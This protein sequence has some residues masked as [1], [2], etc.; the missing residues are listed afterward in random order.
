MNSFTMSRDWVKTLM[1]SLPDYAEELG[2][3]VESA[4]TDHVLDA[5]VA[6]ACALAAALACGNGELAFEISMSDQLRGNDIREAVAKAV[7]FETM[8]VNYMAYATV[9]SQE[10]YNVDKTGY[11]MEDFTEFGGIEPEKFL[12]FCLVAAIGNRSEGSI[13]NKMRFLKHHNVPQGNI[14]SA[15]RI[16]SVIPAIGKCLL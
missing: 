13:R 7:I 9:A 14:Q 3:N 6:H 15:A 8:N 12:L 2:K 10:D 16:A 11:Y 5:E 4:M 1:V